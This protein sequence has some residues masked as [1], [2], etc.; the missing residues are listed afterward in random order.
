MHLCLEQMQKRHDLSLWNGWF[1][2]WRQGKVK[3]FLAWWV[4][5][6][7]SGSHIRYMTVLFKAVINPRGWV[8]ITAGI[9]WNWDYKCFQE[10]QQVNCLRPLKPQLTLLHQMVKVALIDALYFLFLYTTVMRRGSNS[11]SSVLPFIHPVIL[12]SMCLR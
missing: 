8:L 12:G 11:H 6:R 5:V 10:M 7:L 9:F 3:K 1:Y 2:N 4:F